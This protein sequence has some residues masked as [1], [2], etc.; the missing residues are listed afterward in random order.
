MYVIIYFCTL[1]KD[2]T[3]LNK[4]LLL[5]FKYLWLWYWGPKVSEKATLKRYWILV[6]QIHRLG[7]FQLH[8]NWGA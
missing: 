6:S 5:C 2:L 8:A 7:S 1:F 3:Q 4:S